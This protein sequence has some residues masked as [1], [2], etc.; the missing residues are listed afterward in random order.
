MLQRLQHSKAH[1]YNSMKACIAS[2][3][4]IEIS[5]LTTTTALPL[6]LELHHV[7]SHQDK[8]QR[9]THLLPWEAQLNIVCD[10]LAGHQ[11]ESCALDLVVTPNPVCNAYITA[12]L[13]SIT[14]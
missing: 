14:G 1:F 10:K 13:E 2:E 5:I 12:G 9:K 7:R 4:D 8:K 6:T 3:F 11:L